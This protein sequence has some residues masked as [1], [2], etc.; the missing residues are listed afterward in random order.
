M[1]PLRLR[2]RSDNRLPR[3][4]GTHPLVPVRCS[5]PGSVDET[6]SPKV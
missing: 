3:L 5:Q 6:V 4:P 1:Q 2:P